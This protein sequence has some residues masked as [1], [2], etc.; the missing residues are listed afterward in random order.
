MATFIIQ[1]NGKPVEA[2]EVFLAW[3]SGDLA[4]MENATE[5]KTNPVDRHFLLLQL[6]SEFYKRRSDSIMRSKFLTWSRQHLR[7]FPQLAINLKS[8]FDNSLPQVPTFQYLATVLVE[9]GNFDEAICVC[10]EALKY[11]L[12]DGTKFGF[13]GRIDRIQKKQ[14]QALSNSP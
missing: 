4:R 14:R 2:D 13:Q 7:E 5:I 8:E 9:D 1:R 10:D 11:G 3:T 12:D 6:C